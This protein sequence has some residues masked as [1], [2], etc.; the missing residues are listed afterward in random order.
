MC[1]LAKTEIC[2]SVH[3]HIR[4]RIHV[5]IHFIFVIFFHWQ[6]TSEAE[7]WNKK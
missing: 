6:L 7:S 1:I 2:H 4:I 3:I 5:H